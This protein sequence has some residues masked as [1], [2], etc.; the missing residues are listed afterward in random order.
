[1]ATNDASVRPRSAIMLT[2]ATS[3]ESLNL[4]LRC[5]TLFVIVCWFRGRALHVYVV[6]ACRAG[7]HRACVR[8]C[9]CVRATRACAVRI[10]ARIH[11][12]SSVA[13]RA[14]ARSTALGVLLSCRSLYAA[15][16]VIALVGEVQYP[17]ATE[18]NL[19]QE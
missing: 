6:C 14:V 12:P 19:A 13:A 16:E 15:G 3:R 2:L 10:T 8:A 1:M 7:A 9:V 17:Q 11:A 18:K 4:I 5:A